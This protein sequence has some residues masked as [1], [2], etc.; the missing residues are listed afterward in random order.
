MTASGEGREPGKNAGPLVFLIAGEPSGDVLGARLMKAIKA[1]RSGAVRFAGIGGEEMTREGLHSLFPIQEFAVMGFLEVLPH[2]LH[3]IKRI[4]Q[5]VDTVRAQRPDIVVTIDS[6]SFTLEVAQRLKGAGIPLVHYV[7][8]QV[9]AWKARRAKRMARYLDAVLALLPFEPP[10]F[11]VHGLRARFVGHAAVE[12][13]AGEGERLADRSPAQGEGPLLAV[14]PGSRK[15]EVR[16]LLPVF[17]QTVAA[18]AR[19]HPG[20]RVVVPSVETVEAVVREAT[21]SWPVPVEVTRGMEAKHRAFA[22]A[23]ASIA[24]SGTVALELAVAG[25]PTVIAYRLSGF[26]GLLPFSWLDVPYA[27]LVNIMADRMVQPE[28]LQRDCRTDK[29]LEAIDRLLSDPA[30]RHA[31]REA[32]LEVVRALQPASGESPSLSAAREVLAL[33]PQK[34]KGA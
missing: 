23:Q 24:A 11:E 3:I 9:W 1:E 21:A 15:G 19:K 20:L 33:L 12:G 10:L 28:L 13:A 2:V 5:T 34:E 27:S 18:L 7:A 30:A 6:P 8:P 22:R 16:K 25:V 14:L 32:Y 17:E 4:R 29:I 31:Q 26:T